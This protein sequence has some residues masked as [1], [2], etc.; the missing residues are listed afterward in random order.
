MRGFESSR[1]SVAAHDVASHLNYD[2]IYVHMFTSCLLFLKNMFMIFPKSVD[3]ALAGRE[4]FTT[5]HLRE[6]PDVSGVYFNGVRFN[7]MCNAIKSLLSTVAHVAVD[8]GPYRGMIVWFA[9]SKVL[10]VLLCGRLGWV[11]RGS[12][13]EIVG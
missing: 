7:S 8:P 13:K 5:F 1:F 10:I 3:T 11:V 2:M 9:D 6:S 4:Y 12:K